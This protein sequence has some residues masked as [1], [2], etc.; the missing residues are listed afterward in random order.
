MDWGGSSLILAQSSNADP[1]TLYSMILL[2]IFWSPGMFYNVCR[3]PIS[4]IDHVG[5]SH[6]TAHVCP[7]PQSHFFNHYSP[8]QGFKPF[9]LLFILFFR[10]MWP[11]HVIYSPPLPT[12]DLCAMDDSDLNSSFTFP[13][14]FLNNLDRLMMPSNGHALSTRLLKK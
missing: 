13:L 12:V 8:K 3:Y 1:G 14:T 4:T 10:I 5:K 11:L 2:T 9:S 6:L 7:N